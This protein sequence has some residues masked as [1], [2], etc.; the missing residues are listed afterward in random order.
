MVS[1]AKA[2]LKGAVLLSALS[3]GVQTAITTTF[4]YCPDADNIDIEVYK[5]PAGGSPGRDP[6]V[7]LP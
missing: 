2:T 7:A 6:C 5:Y 4:V 3:D 1:E